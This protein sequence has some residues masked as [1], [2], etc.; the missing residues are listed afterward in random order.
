MP[1]SVIRGAVSDDI[2]FTD[3][4]QNWDHVYCPACGQQID[5]WWTHSMGIAHTGNFQNLEVQVPCC[6]ITCSLND[7]KYAWPAGFARFVIEIEDPAILLT[8]GQRRLVE[9]KLGCTLRVILAHY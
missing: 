3:Q 4:G 7:L 1:S 2:Q 6:G 9:E 8:D 5:E